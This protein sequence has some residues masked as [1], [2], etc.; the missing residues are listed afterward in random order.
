[1][2]EIGFDKRLELLFG[3]QYCV[4]KDKNIQYDLLD[5]TN[6]KYYNDFYKV[7]K[8]NADSELIEYI[9]NGGFDTYNR[10][11]EIALSLDENYN[12]VENDYVKT[13]MKNNTSFHK[14]QMEQLLKIFVQKSNYEEFYLS[15]KSYYNQIIHLFREKINKFV[16]FDEKLIIDFYGYKIADFDIKIFS[17]SKGSFGINVN[18][19]IT[20]IANVNLSENDIV[21]VSDT[22]IKT[23]FHEFSHPYCNPLGYKYFDNDTIKNIEYESRLHGLES[24]YSGVT[25]INEYVVRAVQLYLTN[26]YLPKEIYKFE[27]D[28]EKNQSKGYVH[29]DE[30]VK[31]LD[32]KK[33]YDSFE[34]FYK[35]E[36]VEFFKRKSIKR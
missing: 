21:Q 12:I 22:I 24:W 6:S 19:K 15:H 17:F 20:Y 1:M 36:I 32:V 23:L 27:K 4:F 3:L 13:I 28:I 9:E 11:A 30:L 18:N 25:I 5:I 14:V 29:I 10:T 31:L 8:K 35:E 7:Y 33:N 26:K 16:E 2:V 34:E